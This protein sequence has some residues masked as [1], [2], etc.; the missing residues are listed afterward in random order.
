MS[1]SQNKGRDPDEGCGV[2]NTQRADVARETLPPRQPTD[3]E[4]KW[5]YDRVTGRDHYANFPASTALLE[6]VWSA[7]HEHGWSLPDVSVYRIT[8]RRYNAMGDSHAELHIWR[9]RQGRCRGSDEYVTRRVARNPTIKDTR[10][11]LR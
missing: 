5:T 7:V 4:W 11:A 8:L 2:D 6:M 9:D 10:E 3:D 1:N